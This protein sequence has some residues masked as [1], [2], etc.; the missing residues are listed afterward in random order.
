MRPKTRVGTILT[1]SGPCKIAVK[2]TP[3]APQEKATGSPSSRRSIMDP[4]IVIV[5]SSILMS[6]PSLSQ[7]YGYHE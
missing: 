5:I 6:I 7:P 4:N 2:I 3:T 1:A